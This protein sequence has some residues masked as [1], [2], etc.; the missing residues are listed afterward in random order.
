MAVD[1][2]LDGFLAAHPE[3]GGG[4][5]HGHAGAPQVLAIRGVSRLYDGLRLQ[6][7]LGVD[8][9]GVQ[10]VALL[11]GIRGEGVLREEHVLCDAFA[12][13]R[14]LLGILPG[15]D[16]ARTRRHD[17]ELLG[18]CVPAAITAVNRGLR[19]SMCAGVSTVLLCYTHRRSVAI[20]FRRHHMP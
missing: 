13:L 11:V 15:A 6:E 7:L 12:G 2:V 9:A 4:Q 20:V 17:G 18:G 16:L 14:L 5:G 10:G 3:R 1:L 8:V 19:P